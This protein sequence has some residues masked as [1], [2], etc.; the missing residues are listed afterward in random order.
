MHSNNLIRWD[1]HRIGAAHSQ[2]CTNRLGVGRA[3]KE[4]TGDALWNGG[5]CP[6]FCWR[7]HPRRCRGAC[8]SRSQQIRKINSN[9]C[10]LPARTI[11][12]WHILARWRILPSSMT[13]H[14]MARKRRSSRSY[15]LKITS[16]PSSTEVVHAMRTE[17]IPIRLKRQVTIR[18][19]TGGKRK[20]NMGTRV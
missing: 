6:R 10:P 3:G 14:P 20:D 16:P 11:P 2:T 4:L 18:S 1:M 8:R 13:R 5:D 7:C 9:N 19:A 12:L 17:L 15:L